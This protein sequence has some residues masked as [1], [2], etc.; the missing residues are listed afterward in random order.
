MK[1]T[2]KTQGTCSS[3]IEFEIDEKNKVH[4]VVYTHGC[5]GNLKAVGR[6][7]EGWGAN[8]I[9]K[10]LEGLKCRNKDTS[11]ADQLT[12]ALKEITRGK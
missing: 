2:Y 11:C 9:I 7:V 6:L 4:N 5:D 1:H 10:K 12:K 3:L 8:E